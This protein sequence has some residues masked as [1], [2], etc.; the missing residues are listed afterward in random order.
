VTSYTL[1]L[2]GVFVFAISGALAAGRRRLDL[3]GVTVLAAV[4]GVGGGT[5]RDLLLDRHP[6]FWLTDSAYLIVIIVASLATVAY[7]KWARVP[8]RTLDVADAL[9]LALFAVNGARIAEAAGM[10]ALSCV[11]LGAM[12]GAAGGVVRD[13]L[14]AQVPL[15]LKRGSLYVTAAIAGTSLYIIMARAGMEPRVAAYIGMSVVA[16][17][18]MSSIWWGIELPVFE[19]H[20]A[21]EERRTEERRAEPPS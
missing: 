19:M 4:T 12:T 3:L 10:P 8:G 1:D 2:V 13:I 7:V 18:R 21:G 11:L 9:G 17:L 14:T 6:I 16:G 20:G 15:V 5:I